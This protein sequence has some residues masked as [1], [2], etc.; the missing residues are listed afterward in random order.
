MCT[1][2]LVFVMLCG[3]FGK[4]V[5]SDFAAVYSEYYKN[6]NKYQIVQIVKAFCYIFL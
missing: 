4:D 3:F 6:G 2:F 1:C 5:L